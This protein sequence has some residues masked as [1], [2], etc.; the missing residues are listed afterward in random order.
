MVITVYSDINTIIINPLDT[1]GL[2]MLHTLLSVTKKRFFQ[3]STSE[4]FVLE[5]F[6]DMFLRYCVPNEW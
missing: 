3:Y 6:E 5:I 4:A 2:S 1:E